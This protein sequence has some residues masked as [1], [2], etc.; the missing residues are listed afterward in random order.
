MNALK[1]RIPTYCSVVKTTMII[2]K[3]YWIASKTQ[4][5]IPSSYFSSATTSFVYVVS[6]DND[7]A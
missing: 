3:L 4:A 1:K 7:K 6:K 5:V 2:E